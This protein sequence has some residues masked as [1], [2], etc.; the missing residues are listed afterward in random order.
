MSVI[1]ALVSLAAVLIIFGVL[2]A[3]GEG[4]GYAVIISCVVFVSVVPVRLP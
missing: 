4:V 2:V 1:L 3:R